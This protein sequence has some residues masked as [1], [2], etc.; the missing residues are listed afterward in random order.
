M[1]DED[2]LA[3]SGSGVN[4]DPGYRPIQLSQQSGGKKETSAPQPV[5]YAVQR[6]GVKPGRRQNRLDS[7]AGG[8]VT[9]PDGT[10]FPREQHGGG[11][12]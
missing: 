7:R 8:W 12:S 1:V 6:D 10:N 11:L 4:L 5:R 9:F 2:T 3:D